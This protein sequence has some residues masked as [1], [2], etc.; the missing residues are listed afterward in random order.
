MTSLEETSTSSLYELKIKPKGVS[1]E[2]LKEE[3]D[4]EFV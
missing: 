3:V 2:E 4:E 1:L